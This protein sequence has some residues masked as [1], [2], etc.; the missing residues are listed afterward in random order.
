MQAT[1]IIV[2]ILYHVQPGSG[3]RCDDLDF[4][5]SSDQAKALSDTSCCCRASACARVVSHPFLSAWN[6]REDVW[7]AMIFSRCSIW[8]HVCWWMLKVSACIPYV[9]IFFFCRSVQSK[10]ID[11]ILAWQTDGE[12]VDG[13]KW[14][15]IYIYDLHAWRAVRISRVHTHACQ[16][17]LLASLLAGMRMKERRGC[18][19][20]WFSLLLRLCVHRS[21]QVKWNVP[22]Y[23]TCIAFDRTKEG[24][25]MYW[26]V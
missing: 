26:N 24:C 12:M 11:Y 14:Q 21:L 16:G 9:C 20:D 13:I 17:A 6:H 7:P 22:S 18:F 10:L 23:S 8:K 1:C 3:Y 25:R 5:R 4:S 2:W 15:D 19:S